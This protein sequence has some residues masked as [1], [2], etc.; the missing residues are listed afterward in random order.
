MGVYTWN[1][2][3]ASARGFLLAGKGQPLNVKAE[4]EIPQLRPPGA[5]FLNPDADAALL[6]FFLFL[7]AQIQQARDHGVKASK[8]LAAG[9]ES[10]REEVIA[11]R[12]ALSRS[13]L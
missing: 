2:L 6:S 10:P 5:S 13:G 12:A 8:F 4:A 11:I 3:S 1:A 7:A 9:R